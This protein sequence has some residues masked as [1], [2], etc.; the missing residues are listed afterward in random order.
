M[1]MRGLARNGWHPVSGFLASRSVKMVLQRFPNT[2]N[3]TL[4]V[5]GYSQGK[6]RQSQMKG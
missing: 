2:L 6:G 1:L 5:T 4:I 3:K